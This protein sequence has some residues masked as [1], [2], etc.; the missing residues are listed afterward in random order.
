LPLNPLAPSPAGMEKQGATPEQAAEN[1]W[2]LDNRGLV[3]CARKDL[4]PHVAPFAR[5]CGDQEGRGL[6]GTIRKVSRG[7]GGC[8][9]RW[10]GAGGCGSRGGSWRA[11]GLGGVCEAW[12]LGSA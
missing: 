3:T 4:P 2:V 6:L 7:G 1:F 5:P 9:G 11:L 12:N 10:G 8:C